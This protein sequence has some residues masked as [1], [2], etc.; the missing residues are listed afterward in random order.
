MRRRLQ[1][2]LGHEGV[3][4]HGQPVQGLRPERLRPQ[5]VQ[6]RPGTTYN[7]ENTNAGWY[8]AGAGGSYALDS[9]QPYTVVTQF[10]ATGSSAGELGNITRFYIQKGNRVDL[11]T[12]FVL[13][14]TD[15]SHM[16]GFA[17]V[18]GLN[19]PELAT[20]RVL[21]GAAPTGGFALHRTPTI[22]GLTCV[23]PP[24]SIYPAAPPSPPCL[25]SHW[26]SHPQIV[27]DQ[28]CSGQCG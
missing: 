26:F 18:R 12:L 4:R 28:E 19:Q 22:D 3:Q 10:N 1:L 7:T 2:V 13:P 8:G 25:F 27:H 17:E 21:T 23:A 5:S 9:A 6:I 16:G 11:P 20:A 15:G 24:C 14:P